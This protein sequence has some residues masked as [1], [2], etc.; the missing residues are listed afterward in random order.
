MKQEVVYCGI[1][2]TKSRLDVALS[3]QRWELPNTKG[4]M[5]RLVQGLEGRPFKVQVI[6]EASGGY[7]KTLMRALHR[8]G[9]EVTLVQPNRV[10]QFARASGILAKTDRIDAVV[11]VRFAQAIKPAATAAQPLPLLRLRELDTQRAHLTRLLVRE[12]NRLAQLQCVQLRRFT[13]SLI[14]KVQKQI[15]SIDQRVK[16]LIREDET[17]RCKA[18]KLV[19]F[20]GVGERTAALLLA[21]IPE[22][23]QLNRR[24]VAALAGLAPFNRDSG[25]HARQT[26][27]LRRTARSTQR[28]LH[29]RSNRSTI[30]SNIGTLLSPSACRRQTT[31]TRPYRR[32][33]KIT[34]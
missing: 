25:H 28:P 23:G 17:L 31:Q 15:A 18:Q 22:L 11:L 4:A 30:Q 2:V 34:H 26:L 20:N 12:E 1:D 14:H 9:S 32:H 8:S 16:E 5:A 29:V 10:R 19:S 13:R 6:C 21:Q 3:G 24:Q 27:H 7:E 33:A